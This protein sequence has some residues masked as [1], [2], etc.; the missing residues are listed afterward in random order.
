MTK[1]MEM[2]TLGVQHEWPDQTQDRPLWMRQKAFVPCGCG[3]CFG[4]KRGLT[5]GVTHMPLQSRKRGKRPMRQRCH[6]EGC[7]VGARRK[8][9]Q[10]SNVLQGQ[11]K[12]GERQGKVFA[13]N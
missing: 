13:D 2:V 4:C 8:E 12:E 10:M 6:C 3:G 7:Q 11:G 5:N 1:A 9:Q